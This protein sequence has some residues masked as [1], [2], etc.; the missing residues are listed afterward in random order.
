MDT[1]LVL[2]NIALSHD[3]QLSEAYTIRGLYYSAINDPE[4]AIHEFDKAI[5]FNPNDWISY[6]EKGK[7]YRDYDLVQSL[8]N[9]YRAANLNRGQG[10]SVI[11][12][13][14]SEVYRLA[15]ITDMFINFAQQALVLD[16]DSI[17]YYTSLAMSFLDVRNFETSTEFLK[18]AYALDSNKVSVINQLGENYLVLDKPKE[19][20]R[21]FERFIEIEGFFPNGIHRIGYAY[22][23]NGYREEAN[24]YFDKQIKYGLGEIELGRRWAGLYFTYYD[25][26]LVYTF[27]G[28][29]DKAIENLRIFNQ[30]KKMPLWMAALIKDDPMFNSIRDEPEFQQI[31]RDVETKYQAENERVRKWL[32]ENDML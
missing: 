5:K 23:Q 4:Q 30:R 9:Y 6:L 31:V 3:S 2:T 12:R 25:L 8:D 26:A 10:L 14:I 29:K 22:W 32:E 7:L 19:S 27:R 28:E 16:G 15:G 17:E 21:Y 11:L 20:L 13:S 1:V 18:K 24:Y